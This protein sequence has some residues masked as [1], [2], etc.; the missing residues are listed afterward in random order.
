[1][2]TTKETASFIDELLIEAEAKEQ[3]DVLA[4]YDLV[5]AEI[6]RIEGDMREINSNCDKEVELIKEWALNRNVKLQ[7]RIDFLK[8][9]LEAFIREQDKKTIDLPHGT[10][11]LRR[12]PDK[13]EVTDLDLFLAKANKDMVTIVPE[14]IKPSLTAIKKWI[15]MTAKVPE[16]ITVIEGKETFI[17][18][19][20]EETK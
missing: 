9:K 5:V 6:A 14:Q 17:L 3:K 12:T 1:M 13:V 19:L 7:E 20:K 2:E 16:G 11:K 10:L 18:R 8:L 15:K 4:Y